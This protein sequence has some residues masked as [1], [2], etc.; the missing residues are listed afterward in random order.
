VGFDDVEECR[1]TTPPLTSIAPDKMAIATAALDLLVQRM[2]GAPVAEPQEVTPPFALAV[3]EST[4][5]PS[6]GG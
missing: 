5:G 6:I 3:R 2:T 1:Y 4:A